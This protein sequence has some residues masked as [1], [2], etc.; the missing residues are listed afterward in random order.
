MEGQQL[1]PNNKGI[2]I[3]RFCGFVCL[4]RSEKPILFTVLNL[5]RCLTIVFET[6][7]GKNLLLQNC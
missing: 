4:P 1:E 7:D 6:F 3:P 2:E 5:S